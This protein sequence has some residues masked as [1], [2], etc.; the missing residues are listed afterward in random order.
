MFVRQIPFTVRPN[1]VPIITSH[2]RTMSQSFN[3]GTM[4]IV[5]AWTVFE[6]HNSDH[7][8]ANMSL[9]VMPNDADD[10]GG[11]AVLTLR[12]RC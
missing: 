1:T 10:A 9:V 11:G 4:M 12:T 8:E 5:L 7:V 6:N 3:P 2:V